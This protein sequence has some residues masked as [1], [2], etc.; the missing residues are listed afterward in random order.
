MRRA[1]LPFGMSLPGRRVVARSFAVMALLGLGSARA[2]APAPPDLLLGLYPSY[3]PLDMRDPM[4][5][6]LEGFDVDLATGLSQRMGM[7]PRMV[8]T[9]FA[10]LIPSLLTGRIRMFF[11]GMVDTPLR[12]QSVSFVDYLQSGFQFV[13]L[14]GDDHAPSTLPELCGRMVAASRVTSVPAELLAWSDRNCVAKHLPPVLLF[15]TENSADARLQL[16]EGRVVA[17]LQDSLTLPWTVETSGHTLRALGEAF[18]LSPLGIGLPRGD[19]TFICRVSGAF[20]ALQQ[21]GT[22]LSLIHKWHLPESAALPAQPVPE[23]CSRHV[24]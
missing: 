20:S 15:A 16:R 8:E 6:V 24:F 13:T 1:T 12:R 4:T 3:P 23:D 14:S 11:N 2:E 19:S 22:Y 21:D 9:G 5:G 10:Q 18:H 17:A 7:T